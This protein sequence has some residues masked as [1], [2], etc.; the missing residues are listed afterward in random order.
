[1]M[2]YFKC[3]WKTPSSKS[4]IL[5]YI[6]VSYSSCLAYCRFWS[7]GW[8]YCHPTDDGRASSNNLQQN[9][10][11]SRDSPRASKFCRPL[12]KM[13]RN[14]FD[15]ERA[16]YRVA[17]SLVHLYIRELFPRNT[18]I[19]VC[20]VNWAEILYTVSRSVMEFWNTMKV[21]ESFI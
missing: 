11:V 4:T 10:A 19:G 3:T 20:S 5:R 18:R 21:A 1:M 9:S 7:Q 17:P 8:L 15:L 16:K 13:A 14:R 12:S 2:P 6:V